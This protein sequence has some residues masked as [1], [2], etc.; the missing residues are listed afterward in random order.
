MIKPQSSINT[1]FAAIFIN[2]ICKSQ[3]II[4]YIFRDGICQGYNINYL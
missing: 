4:N 3:D 2:F 1:G